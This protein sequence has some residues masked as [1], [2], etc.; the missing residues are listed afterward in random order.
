VF[1]HTEIKWRKRR[2]KSEVVNGETL[3][4]PGNLSTDLVVNQ[5]FF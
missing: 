3:K 4:N 1:F 5:Q 2:E